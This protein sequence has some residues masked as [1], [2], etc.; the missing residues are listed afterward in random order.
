MQKTIST[1]QFLNALLEPDKK[2]LLELYELFFPMI[3][4]MV[5]EG[6]G[7]NEDA[8]D[9]FQDSLEIIYLK[10]QKA[11]FKLT[12]E[13]GT[14]LYSIG[15]NVWYNKLR[16]K[17][18]TNISLSK[19]DIDFPT[20]FNDPYFEKVERWKVYEK[21]FNKLKEDCK[22][23][24]SMFFQKKTMNE[25]A[26]EMGYEDSYPTTKKYNCYKSLVKMIEKDP[27]YWELRNNNEIGNE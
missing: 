6:R 2:K 9:V 12:S 7:N 22:K 13:F 19:L 20:E 23:V 8:E 14:Y 27:A 21:A 1:N 16:K 15:R 10:A 17:S 4:K 11:E 25:I 24:L 5:L 3:K 18:R 26:L